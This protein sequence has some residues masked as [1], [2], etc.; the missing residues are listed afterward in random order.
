MPFEVYCLPEYERFVL[1]RKG[2]DW[3]KE[4][5]TLVHALE[6]ARSKGASAFTVYNPEGKVIIKA[7]Y[8]GVNKRNYSI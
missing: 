5:P 8:R 3:S 1:K 7:P 2:D 6:H 4:F